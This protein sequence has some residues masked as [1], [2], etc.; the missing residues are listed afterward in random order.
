M[1]EHYVVKLLLC[2]LNIRLLKLVQKT[3]VK[4][5]PLQLFYLPI[6]G[7]AFLYYPKILQAVIIYL[8]SIVIMTLK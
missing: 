4:E 8:F 1:Q 2:Q 5:Q 6:F 7:D 3:E